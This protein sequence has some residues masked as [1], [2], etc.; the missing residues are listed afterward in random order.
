[1][2]GAESARVGA[3]KEVSVA[4]RDDFKNA[5]S[6]WASGVTIVTTR[7]D[8]LAH[9]ITASS[10]TSVSLDPPLVLVCV[11]D[12]SPLCAMILSSGRFAVSVL[13]RG[14]EAASNH[15][16][17]RGREPKAVLDGVPMTATSDDLP[18]VAGALGTLA[19]D[20]HETMVL[21]DH[22]VI[23]GRVTEATS[24]S[25]GSPLIYWSRA[26]RGVDPS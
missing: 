3:P 6:A 13:E 10:F 2:P 8:G 19:C 4:L 15:F 20:L 24:A 22:L 12:E 17:S 14:Q 5:M 1:V 18:L 25:E 11:N 16:A 7:A 9:G 21:G 23:V 26:Y